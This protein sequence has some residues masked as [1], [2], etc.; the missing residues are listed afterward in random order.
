MI[1]PEYADAHISGDIHIHDLDFYAMTTTCCQIDIGRLL[2]EGFDTGHGSIRPPKTIRTA[3]NLACIIIQSN[4]N[5]Q[6]GGQSIPN[7]DRMLAPFIDKTVCHYY[8]QEIENY[9]R[10][11]ADMTEVRPSVVV[12]AYREGLKEKPLSKWVNYIEN[13]QELGIFWRT[14]SADSDESILAK[15]IKDYNLVDELDASF[16]DVDLAPI[17]MSE[18]RNLAYQRALKLTEE[19]TLQGMEALVHNLNTMHCLLADQKVRVFDNG[20]ERVMAIEEIYNEFAHGRFE[21]YSFNTKKKRIERQPVLACVDNGAHR[22]L[23]QT[24]TE[25]GRMIVSTPNHRFITYDKNV[26]DFVEVFADEAEHIMYR[27]DDPIVEYE[28]DKIIDKIE[29][30]SGDRH[31]YDLSVYQNENFMLDNGAF[32]HNSRAGAQVPFPGDAR[33]PPDG[34]PGPLLWAVRADPPGHQGRV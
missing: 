27:H 16:L 17:S 2:Q 12:A 33:Q 6:H 1:N 15:I 34:Q 32:V 21:V 20:V 29:S 3:C 4:Q 9:L 7:F 13:S 10:H 18:V 5:D 14:T 31:V 11:L 19:E 26:F 22:P 24:I 30:D 23:I 8:Q 25:Q 28:R